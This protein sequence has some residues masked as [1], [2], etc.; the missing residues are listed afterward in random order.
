M[1]RLLITGGAGF[2]GVNAAG[3]FAAAG[4]AITLLDNLSRPN[5]ERNLD[6]IRSEYP[7]AV[8]FLRAD[9]RDQTT[10]RRAVHGQDAVLHLAA[11]VAVTA[12]ITDPM[13]DFEVNAAGTLGLLEAVRSAAPAAV[14]LYASTNK[15]YGPLEGRRAPVD[16][17]APLDF[18]T[19]YGCSK[20][21]ADQYVRDYS[22]TFGLKTVVLRQSCAYGAHQYGT[23]EQGWVAH[24]VHSILSGRPITIFG[25]GRQ[26]RDLLDARD[27]CRLYAMATDRIDD[28]AGLVFN[29]G[30][31]RANAHSPLEVI[32]SI[33]RRAGIKATYRFDRWRPGD[34]RYYVSDVSRAERALGWEPRIGFEDGLND[35]LRWAQSVKTLQ[36]RAA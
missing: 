30:G 33:E 12:G 5:S 35:L 1:P 34:Q 27:L 31:G 8:E 22:R 28:C 23:E 14:V 13:A 32:A 17:S 24:F 4:W 26:V 19:P 15:V 29:V 10:L 7:R 3:Q 9:V 16:E 25:D 11:Q 20:G 36:P 18:R 6:W 2:L 21:A